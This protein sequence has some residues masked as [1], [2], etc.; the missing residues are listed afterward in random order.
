MHLAGEM[1]PTTPPPGF[2]LESNLETVRRLRTYEPAI[3]FYGHAGPGGDDAVGE[4]DHYEA[5]LPEW[6]EVVEDLREGHGEDV[7][8]IVGALEPGWHSPT[9]HRDVAGVLRYLNRESEVERP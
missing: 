9:V 3:N 8:A 4:L 7:D 1:R 5:M 2:E 6:V